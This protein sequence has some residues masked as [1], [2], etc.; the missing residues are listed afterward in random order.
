M[1]DISM[2][3]DVRH[4]RERQEAGGTCCG[5]PFGHLCVSTAP[6]WKLYMDQVGGSGNYLAATFNSALDPL[7]IFIT[8]AHLHLSASDKI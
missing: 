5:G 6:I 8:A 3:T 7:F 4:I 1:A 2:G